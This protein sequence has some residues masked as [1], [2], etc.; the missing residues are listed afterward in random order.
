M[1]EQEAA[2]QE[3][4]EQEEQSS[5]G[6]ESTCIVCFTETKTHAAAPCGHLVSCEA[7]A[8]RMRS[9]PYCQCE[10]VMWINVREV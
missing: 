1:D 5:Q 6:G 7:C 9:C 2:E 4:A 8:K 10:A 3:A